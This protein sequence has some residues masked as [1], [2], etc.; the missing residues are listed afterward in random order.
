MR[1]GEGFISVGPVTVAKQLQPKIAKNGKHY[2]TAFLKNGASD[3]ML[4]L[5]DGAAGWK[6]PLDTPITL[7]GKFSKGIYN[8]TFAIKCEDL[9]KPEGAEEFKPED[10]QAPIAK[11]SVR[12]AIDAGLRAADYV[13]RK[14]KSNLASAA[15]AFA[16]QA[17]L[18]GYSLQ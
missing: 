12:D 1:D 9:S 18:D 6:L 16:A 3:V 5:W 2:C 10:V 17:F 13:E 7:R 8:G 4:N 15:F 11:P 14:D